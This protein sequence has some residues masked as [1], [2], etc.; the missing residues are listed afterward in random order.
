MFCH[1]C[2][3]QLPDGVKFCPACGT[4]IHR[5]ESSAAVTPDPGPEAAG[6]TGGG[7]QKP[8]AGP[9]KKLIIALCCVAA[10]G[11]AV[12][13]ST[14][15]NGR[16]QRPSSLQL[17]SSQTV[18]DTPQPSFIQ[19]AFQ[20]ESQTPESDDPAPTGFSGLKMPDPYSYFG[21]ESSQAQLEN[22]ILVFHL[23]GDASDALSTYA[24]LFEEEP[25]GMDMVKDPYV[26]DLSDSVFVDY[27][28][29]DPGLPDCNIY[30]SWAYFKEVDMTRAAISCSGADIQS[31]QWYDLG[32]TSPYRVTTLDF[33]QGEA[34]RDEATGAGSSSSGGSSSGG[35]SS[36]WCIAC[37][38]T[39]KCQTCGGTGKVYKVMPGTTERVELE[40]TSCYRDGK[41]RSCGG[42]GRK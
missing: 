3:K 16:S 19:P 40:C 29:Q 9:N 10:V 22:D 38:G 6:T 8:P 17:P 32:H 26:A 25:F 35:S 36:S 37:G 34:L 33:D 12:L 31:V 13:L 27:R 15:L 7:G 11:A 2:G 21:M 1:S 4:K 41:C 23:D 24:E 20:E 14:V 18:E 30:V 28:F 42:D 5:P 39:G